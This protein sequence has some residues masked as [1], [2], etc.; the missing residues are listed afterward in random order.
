MQNTQWMPLPT[1]DFEAA[2]RQYL[3]LYGSTLVTNRYLG[4]ALLDLVRVVILPGLVA[5]TARL[6]LALIEQFL[7]GLASGNV[8]SVV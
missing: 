1:K 7:E 8:T 4:V 3:E 6:H 2:K 5:K